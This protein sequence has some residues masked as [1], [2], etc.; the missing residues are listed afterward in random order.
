MLMSPCR[1]PTSWL[2]AV[3]LGGTIATIVCTVPAE[4][5]IKGKKQKKNR[6]G[7]FIYSATDGDRHY[8]LLLLRLDISKG[9][10]GFGDSICRVRVYEMIVRCAWV[11]KKKTR[12]ETQHSHVQS[13]AVAVSGKNSDFL[14]ADCSTTFLFFLFLGLCVT[15]YH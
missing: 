2:V 5:K 8:D 10:F 6:N 3:T 15:S 12:V 9:G 1:A 11:K 13:M 7:F 4:E 14:S